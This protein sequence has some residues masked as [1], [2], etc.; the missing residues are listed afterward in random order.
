M[1]RLIIWICALLGS[2]S[3][4]TRSYGGEYSEFTLSN[5]FELVAVE[6]NVY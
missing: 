4:W 5:S 2:E 6:S 1:V 3:L